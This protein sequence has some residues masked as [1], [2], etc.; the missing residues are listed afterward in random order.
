MAEPVKL[1][2]CIDDRPELINGIPGTMDGLRKG[3]IYVVRW[4]GWFRGSLC[5]K[6]VEISN[7][8]YDC[9]YFAHRFRPVDGR[10][11]DVFRAIIET[12]KATEGEGV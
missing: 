8:K 4:E 12:A 10:K 5:I 6:V 2:E 9:P 7:R 11:I 1:V 3:K